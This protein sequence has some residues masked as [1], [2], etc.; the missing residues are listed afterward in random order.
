MKEATVIGMRPS[1][2]GDTT[3]DK[4]EETLSKKRLSETQETR[5][6]ACLLLLASVE[7][8]TVGMRR[9]KGR[10]RRQGQRNTFKEAI[11]G[12]TGDKTDGTLVVLG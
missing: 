12:D 3:G 2:R 9:P 1:P 7:A 8:A 6:T 4:A 5:P 10:H 11:V